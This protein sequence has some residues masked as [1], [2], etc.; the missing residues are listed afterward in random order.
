MR[1]SLT[2]RLFSYKTCLISGLVI[3]TSSFAALDDWDAKGPEG[4]MVYHLSENP[5]GDRL[6][7]MADGGF[8]TSADSCGT[9]QKSLDIDGRA[10]AYDIEYDPNDASVAYLATSGGLYKST[11]GGAN[12]ELLKQDLT[13][14][15]EVGESDS[16]QIFTSSTTGM[17]R[18]VNGGQSWTPINQGIPNSFIHDFEVVPDSNPTT[19][20]AGVHLDG[21]YKSTDGGDNWAKLDGLEG[22]KIHDIALTYE[23]ATLVVWVKTQDMAFD[24]E[25]DE[26]IQKSLDGGDTWSFVNGDLPT[27]EFGRQGFWVDQTTGYLYTGGN[28]RTYSTINELNW[29]GSTQQ[30][31]QFNNSLTLIQSSTDGDQ[32]FLGADGKGV[33]NMTDGTNWSP[34]NVGLTAAPVFASINPSDSQSIVAVDTI[35]DFHFTTDGGDSWEEVATSALYPPFS[36]TH[37]AS[38]EVIYA[39]T[40]GGFI[41]TDDSGSTPVPMDFLADLSDGDVNYVSTYTA[42]FAQ[43]PQVPQTLYAGTGHWVF[44]SVNG[45]TDWAP[46]NSGMENSRV[47]VIAVSHSNSNDLVAGTSFNA[48]G[49]SMFY[50]HNGGVT[51]TVA[52]TGPSGFSTPTGIVADPTDG[53]TY[54]V[55]TGVGVFKSTDR[56]VNWTEANN[57][58]SAVNRYLSGIAIDPANSQR[59]V[60]TNGSVVLKSEDGAATWEFFNDSPAGGLVRSI[61]FD[62]NEAGLVMV[63]GSGIFTTDQIGEAPPE[64]DDIPNAFAF[65]NLT[66]V[67]LN[68][69][70]ESQPIQITGIDSVTTISVENGEYSISTNNS[71][72]A[73]TVTWVSLPGSMFNNQYVCVRHTS[74][75]SN[76]TVTETTLTVGGISASFS[77]TTKGANGDGNDSGSDDSG[78]G[79]LHW[80]LLMLGGFL[81]FRRSTK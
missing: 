68:T 49:S 19:L 64:V 65:S 18:S 45:G 15:V 60:V 43:D 46:L 42:G 32:F 56:G 73:T 4:G 40:N 6:F 20:F 44:K 24:P 76:Q 1:S 72:D 66:N 58:I 51:W 17:S 70:Y 77:T 78:S 62:P 7:A 41:A 30:T 37:S 55:S 12:W 63:A 8:F 50:S 14:S 3:S 81:V 39:M 13:Y 28:N 71:C 61:Q 59:L 67:E 2:T 16:D 48:S 29:T 69:S 54:Y 38:G 27:T 35:G 31:K 25:V 11:N 22:N 53:S 10:I 52:T 74:A 34:C 9:W 36:I 5:A 26:G 47:D 23:D 80:L 57:G 21:L 33:F 79:S 75:T